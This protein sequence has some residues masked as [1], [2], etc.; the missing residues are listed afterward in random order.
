MV[1]EWWIFFML[2][3]SLDTVDDDISYFD[4][5]VNYLKFDKNVIIPTHDPSGIEKNYFSSL[6]DDDFN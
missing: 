4:Y 1:I 2:R 6:K 5:A 3:I